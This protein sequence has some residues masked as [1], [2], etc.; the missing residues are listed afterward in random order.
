M[1]GEDVE[2]FGPFAR[3]P[4][5][6][7]IPGDKDKVQRP[8]GVLGLKAAHDPSHALV[9]ARP[10]PPALDPE[11]ITLADDMDVGEMRDAP[12]AA[13]RWRSVERIEVEWLIHRGVGEA[14]DERSRREVS[15]HDD[16]SVCERGD[17]QMMRDGEIS[18]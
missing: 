6:G 2:E 13:V 11:A 5:V 10:A 18:G 4:G 3:A 7:H 15:R 17:D 8:G 16:D 12:D 14:P 9:A 1:A